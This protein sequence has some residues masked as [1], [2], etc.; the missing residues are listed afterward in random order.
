MVEQLTGRDV[1][2]I[3]AVAFSDG[4]QLILPETTIRNLQAAA[5]AAN[6]RGMT[7]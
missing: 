2:T 7:P 3:P 4:F 1:R 5:H 6:A